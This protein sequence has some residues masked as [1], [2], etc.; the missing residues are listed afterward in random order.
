MGQ[1]IHPYGFRVGI[2]RGWRSRWFA[3]KSR[4]GTL[5]VEDAKIREFVKKRLRMAGIADI[6]IERTGEEVR[7]LLHSARPGLVIGRKHAEVDRLRGDIQ[8]LTGKRA[9]VNI[10]EVPNPDA[11]AQLLADGVAAQ[12]CKRV[13]FRRAMRRAV[14]SAR[15]AGA[16]GVKITCG[17]RL[18]GSEMGRRERYVEGKLPLHT[19]DADIDYGLSEAKTTY[20]ILGVKV[21]LYKGKIENKKETGRA[22]DAKTG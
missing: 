15:H 2:T 18:G 12:L 8:A 10:R 1:K 17:G 21:W 13:S 11:S 4:F 22:S 20:G 9:V 5:V 3:D 6:E 14:E 16:L 7:L 19:L